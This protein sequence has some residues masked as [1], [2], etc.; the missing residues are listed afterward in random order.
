MMGLFGN[1][2]PSKSR[3][4]WDY[5]AKTDEWEVVSCS[6]DVSLMTTQQDSM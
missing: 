2:S 6:T 3:S 4:I 5:D 1:F